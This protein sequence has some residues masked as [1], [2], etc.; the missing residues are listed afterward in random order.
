MRLWVEPHIYHSTREVERE[1]RDTLTTASLKLLAT[2]IKHY[3][4]VIEE[5]KQALEGTLKE[6]TTKIKETTKKRET[7]MLNYGE[8]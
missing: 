1:W 7:H 6:V 3:T 5:E 4:K 8:N 2:L